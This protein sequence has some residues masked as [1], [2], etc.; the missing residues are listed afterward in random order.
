MSAHPSHQLDAVSAHPGQQAPQ[1]PPYLHALQQRGGPLAKNLQGPPDS[2]YPGRKPLAHWAAHR[3]DPASAHPGH[4]RDLVSAHPG[5]QPQQPPPFL[6]ASQQRREHLAN[7]SQGHHQAVS[8]HPGQH[9]APG[10]AHPG[11][12]PTQGPS[13]INASQH[14]GVPLENFRAPPP[15]QHTPG[16][17]GAAHAPPQEAGLRADPWGCKKDEREK[18]GD[19]H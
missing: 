1:D 8:A 3:P 13:L 18:H 16:G 10:S 9:I 15:D 2:H 12:Q 14:R 17:G 5:Q 7:F 6:H 4:Q 19:L 11:H